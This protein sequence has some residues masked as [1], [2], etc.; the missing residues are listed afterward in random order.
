MEVAA[1][2]RKQPVAAVWG[3]PHCG[4]LW[5]GRMDAITCG[6]CGAPGA[7]VTD[8]PAEAAALGGMIRWRNHNKHRRAA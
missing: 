3:C 8:D 2:E 4:A 5:I 1:M 6:F 7:E